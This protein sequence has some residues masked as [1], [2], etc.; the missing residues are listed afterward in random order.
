MVASIEFMGLAGGRTWI[1]AAA[2]F[3][4]GSVAWWAL[5]VSP[6]PQI[7][8]E[9]PSPAPQLDIG[10]GRDLARAIARLVHG[11]D[12]SEAGLPAIRG[13]PREARGLAYVALRID[14][15]RVATAWN[16]GASPIDALGAALVE[17]RDDLDGEERLAV[18]TV[19]VAIVGRRID[20]RSEGSSAAD[21]LDRGILGM[22]V[23]GD[24]GQERRYSP[25][26]MIADNTSFGRIIERLYEDGE[27]VTESLPAERVELFEAT[28]LLVDLDRSVVVQLER[29]NQVVPAASV[30]SERTAQLAEGMSDWLVRQLGDDGRM[31]YEYWPSRGEESGSNN[32]IRQWMATLALTRIAEQ[33]DDRELE[34]KVEAN[35]AYNLELSYRE[36]GGLGLIADPDGEVKLGAVA[37]AALAI[38][39]HPSR[40]RFAAEEAALRRMVDHLWQPDGSFVTFFIPVGRNDN[41]NFY[42]GEALLLWATTI[43]ADNDPELLERFMRSF[44]HYR[45]WHREQPNPAFVPWHTMAYEKVWQVTDDPE[46]RDFVFEMNDWLLE[47]Q[48]WGDAPAPDVAGRFY[49]PERPDYGPPHASSDG[50]YL[51]GLI[52]AYRLAAE[53]GDESRVDAYRTAIARGLRHLM[54]LQFADEVDMYYVL[55]R[56]R[57]AG[58]MRTTVYDNVIRVDNVQHALLAVID[59]LDAFSPEDYILSPP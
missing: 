9:D 5:N 4:V 45:A 40:E 14:G 24:D 49:N 58:G 10:D 33:R 50:V 34:A 56:E 47:M 15:E 59:V 17:A 3:L 6:M 23:T 8:A 36:E 42:P 43:A 44:E 26:Q 30:T 54:Q 32:M 20:A 52:S 21:N 31:V 53:V 37:L 29:G 1:A 13:L 12:G 55:K 19:E 57:V 28:Q 35:I 22:G 27:I 51:E 48:Q 41:Q 18:N 39:E 7:A 11:A 16:D 25:T 2:V 38:S 46:L